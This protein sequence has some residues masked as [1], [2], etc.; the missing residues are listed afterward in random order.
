MLY[1][2]QAFSVLSFKARAFTTQLI[3]LVGAVLLLS[4]SALSL[5]FIKNKK[6]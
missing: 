6:G 4:L 1:E 5:I 3:V 2:F